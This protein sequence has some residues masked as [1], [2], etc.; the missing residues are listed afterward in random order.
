MTLRRIARDDG[1]AF[2]AALDQK[3][4]QTDIEPAFGFAIFSMAMEALRLQDGAHMFF[5]REHLA[6]PQGAGDH[7]SDEGG[8]DHA[9]HTGGIA[10]LLL[11]G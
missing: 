10:K 4:R 3:A 11:L 2:F 7:E 8:T 6:G 1:R 5:K 9:G